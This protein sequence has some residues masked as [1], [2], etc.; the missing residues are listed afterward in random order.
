M[1]DHTFPY[2]TRP[3]S[4]GQALTIILENRNPEFD[5]TQSGQGVHFQKADG[6]L[7]GGRQLPLHQ[8][9]AGP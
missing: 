5:P 9:L 4:A 8:S 7:R 6:H 1:P 2:I 3:S